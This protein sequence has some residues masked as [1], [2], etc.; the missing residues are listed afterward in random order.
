MT[1]T[2]VRAEH[3]ATSPWSMSREEWWK[4]LKRTWAEAGEDNIGLIGAWSILGVRPAQ[5]LRQL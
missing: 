3:T 4:V 5:A 1:N 2:D